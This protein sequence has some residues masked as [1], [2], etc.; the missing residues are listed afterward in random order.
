VK[1]GFD[2]IPSPPE[3]GQSWSITQNGGAGK[4]AAEK[5]SHSYRRV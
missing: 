5:K 1:C 3:D 4:G 2:G